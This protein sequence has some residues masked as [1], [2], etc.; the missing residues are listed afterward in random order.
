MHVLFKKLKEKGGLD[1]LRHSTIYKRFRNLQEMLL[2]H[3]A[4]KM[5]QGI[6][7]ET[8]QPPQRLH[9]PTHTPSGRKMHL[10]ITKGLLVSSTD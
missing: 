8:T 3:A 2:G 6:E 7:E 10:E 5:N 9:V 1:W 4:N